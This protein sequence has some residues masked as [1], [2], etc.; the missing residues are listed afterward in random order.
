[1]KN[2]LIVHGG[3]P[4][5]VLN[6]SLYGTITEAKR[7]GGVDRIL[8]A[9]NGTAGFMAED[10]V[11]LTGTS[12]AKL[13][14]LKSTP[15]TA[16]GTSRTPLYE[17]EYEKMR[18]VCKNHA[19]GYVIFNGGNGTMD[20]CSNL[21]KVVDTD[22]I[23]VIGIPKTVDNDLAI[24]DHSPGYGS[25]AKFTACTVAEVVQDVKSM[26]I[27]VSIIETMGRNAGWIT[28]AAAL[29]GRPGLGGPHMI[30]PPEVHFNDEAFLA[31]VKQLHDAHGGVVIVASEGLR[32]K[33]GDFIVKPIWTT[34]RATYFGDV[35]T[36][37][38]ELVIKN[39]GIK[40][41]SEKP[42]IIARASVGYQSRTDLDEAILAGE[43]A[44]RLAMYGETGKMV[45]LER[46]SNNPY[47]IRTGSVGIDKVR[48][49]EKVLPA[50]FID[51]ENFQI[52]DNFRDYCLPLI[53][54][55]VAD[56]CSFL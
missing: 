51:A 48:L 31:R 18:E 11:D 21:A 43:A 20:T 5:P 27:H 55:A 33:S 24:T 34:E 56:F 41:R 23:K 47:K 53:D 4:T 8:G 28:A 35:G 54:G 14:L 30:L 9:K 1:M 13:E 44:V 19:I 2:L 22:G 42:G 50:E 45:T 26:P 36:H 49:E 39:L 29:A 25:I 3:G 38:A 6:G 17:A 46:V 40:S 37:L 32:Y 52:N 7:S 10:F 15:G 16:I 12:L